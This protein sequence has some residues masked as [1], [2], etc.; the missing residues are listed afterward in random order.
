MKR[1]TYAKRLE[2]LRDA[3]RRSYNVFRFAADV[4]LSLTIAEG[5][6]HTEDVQVI[7][8]EVALQ[9]LGNNA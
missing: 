3:G 2:L 9:K 4:A 5:G 6:V 1:S 8:E 7:A